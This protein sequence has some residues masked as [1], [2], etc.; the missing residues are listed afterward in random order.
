MKRKQKSKIICKNLMRKF[1][2]L[3]N[4]EDVLVSVIMDSLKEIKKIEEEELCQST[5]MEATIIYKRKTNSTS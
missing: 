2:Y 4:Q 5:Y 1:D 3:S